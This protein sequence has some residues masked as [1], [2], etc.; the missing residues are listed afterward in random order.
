MNK[1]NLLVGLLIL[2]MGASIYFLSLAITSYLTPETST[3]F[4]L[5]EMPVED[6]VVLRKPPAPPTP[7]E[8]A[9]RRDLRGVNI[10]SGSVGDKM[11]NF[12][13]SEKMDFSREMYEIK[14]HQFDNQQQPESELKQELILLATIMDA[15]N[16]LEIELV[17]HTHDAGTWDDQQAITAIRS[18]NIKQFLIEQGIASKRINASGYGATYPIADNTSDRGREMNER[19]EVLIRAL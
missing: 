19:I 13:L 3:N 7:E 12:L 1:N 8:E 10:E 11:L 4:E 6:P 5:A 16:S 18:E 17:A 2:L 9:A 15:Y 14:Y